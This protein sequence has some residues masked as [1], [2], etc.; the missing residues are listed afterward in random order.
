ML[1]FQEDLYGLLGVAEAAAPEDLRK[2]YLKLAKKLHPDRFPNDPEQ[3]AAAQAEFSRVTRAHDI[4][5]D[6]K[7]RQEYDAIRALAK[8]RLALEM[9]EAES[10]P[11]A[12]SSSGGGTNTTSA[13]HAGNASGTATA[14]VATANGT[15]ATATAPAPPAD[16]AAEAGGTAS[17]EAWAQKHYERAADLLRKK[18]FPEAE[19]A[20]KESIR[21]VPNNAGYHAFLAEIQLARGWKTLAASSI[22]T[23]LA[24]D[25]KNHEAKQVELRL[26]AT[27]MAN[28]TGASGDKAGKKEDKPGD[29]KGFM[30]QLK[31]LLNKKV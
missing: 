17:K 28:K 15:S 25:P 13:A 22:Q 9:G 26:K 23:A 11:P 7:Q 20:I 14:G 27:T 16:K 24:I 2:A 8:S 30:D 31:D 21:L 4:L 18:K 6:P 5:S 3:R 10:A 12:A 19:T 29:K 1:E